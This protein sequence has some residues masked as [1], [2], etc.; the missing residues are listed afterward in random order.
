M[1][2]SGT[3]Q[4]AVKGSYASLAKSADQKSCDSLQTEKLVK[5]GY[6]SEELQT[7][8]E[9]VVTLA[10][11]CGSPTALATIREGDT[12]LDMGS[13]GGV[14]VFLASRKVGPNGRVIGL[15]MTPDMVSWAQANAVKLNAANVEFKLGQIE[16][17]PLDAE[18]VDVIM[19]NCVIC[20]STDKEQVFQEMFRVLRPGGRLAI[21]DE[22]ALRVFS[23]EEKADP[24]KWCSCITGAVTEGVY[25][26]MLENVGFE[27]VY[28]KQLRK[29]GEST[30][31]VFS[32]FISGIK[33]AKNRSQ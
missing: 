15:D 16:N 32:A 23:E 26:G 10:D 7:L 30:S 22:V 12:V 28:V 19:S 2:K 8:P 3:I 1:A 31:G 6:S 11:G 18:S 4:E 29:P 14:D 25:A 33:P 24:S 13:G 21:A 9:S 27:E 20:L 5:Y 17:I